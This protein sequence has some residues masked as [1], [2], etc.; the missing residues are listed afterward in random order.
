MEQ[1]PR[2]LY[3]FC[4]ARSSLLGE[5]EG[6]GVD[7]HEPLGLFRHSADLCAVVSEVPRED[8]CGPAADAQIQQLAWVGPRALRHEAVVEQV[9]RRSPVLPA[10]FGTLFSSKE[11]LAEFL[12]IHRQRIAQFLERVTGQEEWSVRGL[13]R[14][15]QAGEALIAASQVAQE[16]ELATLPPGTRYFQE[17]HIRAEAEKGLSRWLDETCREAANTLLK[18]A[19][20]FRECQVLPLEPPESGAEVV[21]NWAFLL[22][23]DAAAAF[24]T[25][26]KGL[27]SRLAPQGLVFELSGPW[28]PY[29]FVPPLTMGTAP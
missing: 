23:R 1:N 27:S 11:S 19:S 10:R 16:A 18:Q 3:L 2:A 4:F 7:G 25:L 29:R 6:A 24:R 14:R 13:L 9:M 21:L 8:F 17:K 22:P 20:D 28:P 5:I 12:D 15:K 26:V